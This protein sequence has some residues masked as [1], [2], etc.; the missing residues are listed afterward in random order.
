MAAANLIST[1]VRIRR[2]P[3][4]TRKHR[5]AHVLVLGDKSD[6][7]GASRAL[8]PTEG[9][10]WLL[11]AGQEEVLLGFCAPPRSRRRSRKSRTLVTMM[12][13]MNSA[14]GTTTSHVR[15]PES[16]TTRRART[17]SAKATRSRNHFTSDGRLILRCRSFRLMAVQGSPLRT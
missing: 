17:P 16:S 11:R 1:S 6:R 4:T 14:C 5:S 15:W 12:P 10:Q 7:R 3:P 8:E 2:G 13:T 9:A